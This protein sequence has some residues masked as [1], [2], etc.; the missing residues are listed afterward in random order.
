MITKFKLFESR[1]S[2][3]EIHRICREYHITGYDINPDG[4][5]SV[6]GNVGV[7]RRFLK[8]IPLVF[9]EVSG[10]FYCNHNQLTSLEGCPEKV[11]GDFLCYRNNLTNLEGCPEKVDGDFYCSYNQLT[12]LKGCPEKVGG[13]F[14]CSFNQLTSLEGCPDA[15]YIHCV[16]NKITSFE[17]IPE[18][19][20]G[21][22]NIF[23]NPVDEI[24]K[25]FN[26][27]IRCI[28]LINEFDVIQGDRVIKDRLEEVFSQ[29]NMEIPKNIKL[30]S[31]I[32]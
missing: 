12:S 32:F 11:G 24:F 29:L 18:F 16:N 8:K 20:E 1:M 30:I 9:K 21:E 6:D 28:D 23:S 15:R 17:G 10:Y 7:T 13:D 14:Y 27:D 4:S 2:D 31:Y 19:W 3:Q 25:L 26:R 5:I 22:L